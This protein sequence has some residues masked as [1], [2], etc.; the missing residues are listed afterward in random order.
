MVSLC[1]RDS[2]EEQALPSPSSPVASHQTA[3]SEKPIVMEEQ[4]QQQQQPAPQ[5]E[6]PSPVEMAAAMIEKIGSPPPIPAA[7]ATHKG[8]TTLSSGNHLRTTPEQQEPKIEGKG[9]SSSK[10]RFTC[11]V[12]SYS[13][14]HQKDAI[15]TYRR[16]AIKT[17]NRHVQMAYA[18]Y[19]LD[20]A[21][22]YD[23]NASTR[24]RLLDE[25]RYWISRLAKKKMWEAV[26]LQGQHYLESH[27]PAKATRCFEKAAK[28][29]Y[30]AAY[31]AL[32]DQ[33]E[34]Q[35]DWTKALACYRSAA[36]GH[37]E[38]N[39]KMAMV[40][41]RQNMSA[42]QV[43]EKAAK[44]GK[45]A[46]SGKAA[47]VLSKIYAH[48]LQTREQVEK[49]ESRAFRYLKQAFQLDLVEAVYQMG[50][51]HTYGLLGQPGD[52]WQGYQC[53][54]KAAEEGYDLAMLELAKVYAIGIQG[55]L[56]QQPDAAFR[57]CQRAA[58]RGLKEAEYTLGTYYELGV[59]ISVDYPRAL[60][61]F[62][63]AASKGH[64]EAAEKLN[65]PV[66]VPTPPAVKA[67]DSSPRQRCHIM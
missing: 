6:L 28:H 8:R 65:R 36:D 21:R 51:V 55:F 14:T 26:F 35:G 52:A 20:V 5:S 47:L 3:M 17:K 54:M 38:A 30:L 27:Q 39:Y 63:K 1:L 16:M 62:G 19:L 41:L 9:R 12:A 45:A 29:G 57:W 61:Y 7:T 22:L 44:S 50:Q 32:A 46:E 34:E 53:F 11:I 31:L 4:Q 13:L 56:A 49:N 60:E 66:V 15:K 67:Q 43:L 23:E 37:P 58:E 59:G 24:Q 64:V 33:A 42:I 2:D 25:G 40:L 10:A 48:T 18:K